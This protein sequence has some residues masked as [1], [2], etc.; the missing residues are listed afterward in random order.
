[1]CRMRQHRCRQPV[2]GQSWKWIGAALIISIHHVR[3]CYI[4]FQHT[5]WF[6][7]TPLSFWQWYDHWPLLPF[8]S[9]TGCWQAEEIDTAPI[10]IHKMQIWEISILM[11][12]HNL[13]SHKFSNTHPQVRLSSPIIASSLTASIKMFSTAYI[14]SYYSSR[15][16][17][18][19]I[20]N[21]Q[22]DHLT[23]KRII[24]RCF[25]FFNVNLS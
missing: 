8:P 11:K 12:I 2:W 21:R 6:P 23:V 15:T 7:L 1:M 25:G 19:F 4:Y 18:L 17:A 24:K 13:K 10:N 16:T 22:L 14:S 3:K 9:P 20:W 5:L